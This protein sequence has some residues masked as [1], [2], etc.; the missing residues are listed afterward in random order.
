MPIVKEIF[1]YRIITILIFLILTAIVLIII[2][3]LLNIIFPGVIFNQL[4]LTVINLTSLIS[5]IIALS[6][7][8]IMKDIENREKKKEELNK[9]KIIFL[10]IKKYL[11]YVLLQNTREEQS[12]ELYIS[13]K[14]PFF[15]SLS[16]SS[17]E[18][19]IKV[20]IQ[21]E[22]FE[23]RRGTTEVY[24]YLLDRYKLSLGYNPFIKKVRTT[25]EFE[26][27]QYLRK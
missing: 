19:L 6:L 13:N 9:S 8:F 14:A 24:L 10:R 17:P 23:T 21:V 3:S 22:V 1:K 18:T 26:Y 27:T 25:K 16:Q 5:S 7:P 2:F 15:L 4:S 12:Q 11:E 20:G